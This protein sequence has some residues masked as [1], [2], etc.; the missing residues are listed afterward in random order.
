MPARKMTGVS[1]ELDVICSVQ[2]LPARLPP[3]AAGNKLVR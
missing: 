1:I 2:P 3:D